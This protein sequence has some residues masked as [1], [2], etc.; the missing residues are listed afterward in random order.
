MEPEAL[1]LYGK[2]HLT[3]LNKMTSEEKLEVQ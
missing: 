3:N 1:V 2:D